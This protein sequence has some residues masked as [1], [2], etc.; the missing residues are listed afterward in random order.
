MGPNMTDVLTS[1]GNLDTETHTQG[2]YSHLQAKE[3]NLRANQSSSHLD[4]EILASG[5]V[6]I[7]ICGPLLGQP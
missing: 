6:R 1:R 5:T 4:L 7:E 3:T 2:D